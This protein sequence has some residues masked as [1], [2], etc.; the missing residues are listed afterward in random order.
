MQYIE[1]FLYWAGD[2]FILSMFFGF[3]AAYIESFIPALPIMAIAAVN[4]A[5]N[6]L[7]PGFLVSWLGTCAG[8]ISVF[9]LVKKLVHLDFFQKRKTK[10]VENIIY[11]IQKSQFMVIFLFYT[12]P[13][14][15]SSMMTIAAAFCDINLK[16]FVVPMLFGKFLM[17]FMASYIG[18]DIEGFIHSPLKICV[19]SIIVIVSYWMANRMK[20][21][22]DKIYDKR[23]RWE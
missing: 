8:V 22:I 19:V 15:P 14:L 16:D 10:K 1:Q 20:K 7:V 17:M 2:Y 5:I 11:K 18:S 12:I 4:A 13:V 6:G 23:H 3:L 9:L 21:D